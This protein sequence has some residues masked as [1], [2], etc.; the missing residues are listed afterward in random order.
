[1][2]GHEG[3]VSEMNGWFLILSDIA[4]IWIELQ[5]TI[6]LNALQFWKPLKIFFSSENCVCKHATKEKYNVIHKVQNKWLL[7]KSVQVCLTCR[8]RCWKTRRGKANAKGVNEIISTFPVLWE[9]LWL[10]PPDSVEQET[11]LD[12]PD[13]GLKPKLTKLL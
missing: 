3:S 7:F 8:L 4:S 6:N 12:P 11:I 10:T 1:M 5:S 9:V 2:W 13:L